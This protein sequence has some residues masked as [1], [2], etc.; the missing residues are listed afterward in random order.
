[1][2]K[3]RFRVQVIY[4]TVQLLQW[5]NLQFNPDLLWVGTDDGKVWLTKNDGKEWTDV[6]IKYYRTSRLLG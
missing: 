6:T 3:Q 1:M 5:K 2:M 4:S